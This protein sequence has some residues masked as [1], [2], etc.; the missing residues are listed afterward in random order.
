M[1]GVE[2]VRRKRISPEREG[3]LHFVGLMVLITLMILISYYDVISPL[4]QINWGLK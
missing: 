4:P 2:A 3:A 1:V